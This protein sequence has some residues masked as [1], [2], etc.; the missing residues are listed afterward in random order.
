V[1]TH[2]AD[3]V[4]WLADAPAGTLDAICLDVDN[5]PDWL[6]SPGNGWLYEDDGLRTAAKVLSP[7][8]VLTIWSA[9]PSPALVARM[10]QHFV[11]VEVTEVPVPRGQPDV[12]ML[13]R[14]PR[15]SSSRSCPL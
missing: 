8:G 9:A 6:L 14:M 4:Q 7:Q 11:A 10:Q 2:E 5:G 3:V 15:E 13:G 12:I 1:R